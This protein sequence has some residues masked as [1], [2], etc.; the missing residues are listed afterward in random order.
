MAENRRVQ[1]IVSQALDGVVVEPRVG[2][3]RA[4]LVIRTRDGRAIP[5]EVKWAGEGWPQ[6]VRRVAAEVPD[7]WPADV[8]LLAHRLSPGAIEWLRERGANWADEVGQ[9]RIHGPGGLIVIREPAEPSLRGR[10]SRAF[11]WSPSAIV[12][13]EAILSTSDYSLRAAE[14]AGRSG[15]SVAQVANVLA[16]FDAQHWTIKRGP[17]RGPRAHRELID[18]NGLLASWSDAVASTPRATRTA[19]RAGRDVMRLL[20]ENVATAL[21]RRTTWSLSGWGAME[22]AAPFVTTTPNLQ[23][24]VDEDDFAGALSES[25]EEAG[26]REVDDGGRVTFWACDPR[27]LALGTDHDGLPIASAP[28][29]HADLVAFGARGLDAAAHIKQ[30]LI[31]PLHRASSVRIAGGS[32]DG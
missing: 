20:R 30:Q 18:A 6:D 23:I 10:K 32:D 7:P 27:V 1:R 16:A 13:A 11:N 5:I 12:V 15:W 17:V 22:L 4:D 8:V 21:D 28:R 9:A 25:I 19:H 26:L 29:I 14:L 31:D 2:R 24:Y 3:M